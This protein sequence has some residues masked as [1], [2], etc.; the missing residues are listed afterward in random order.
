MSYEVA[1]KAEGGR[2]KR[3]PAYRDSGVEWLGSCPSHWCTARIRDHVNLVNGYPFDSNLFD[4][5]DGIPLVRIRDILNDQTGIVWTGEAVP[6]AAI[7]N[8]DILIGMDGDFNVSWWNGGYAMLNQRVCCIRVKTNNL[9]Q[10]FIFYLLHFPLKIINNLAYSTTVK[11]LSSFDVLK[12]RFARP[13]MEEQRAIA[14]FLDS[15]TGRID[16]LIAKKERQIELLREKRAA[17]ISHAVTRGLDPDAPMKD[18]GVE[19]LGEVPVG[20]AA[21]KTKYVATLRTGHTPGRQ[22]PEYWEDCIIPWFSL[23]DVW[24]LRDGRQEYLGETKEKIS[25]LGLANSSAELLPANTVIVSRTASVGFSGIMPE[26]M[27]TTQD[28]VNWVCSPK[29]QPEYLLYVFRSMEHEFKRLTMGSTH[30][31]IYMPDAASFQTPVPSLGEQKQIVKY[32]QK[33][34]RSLERVEDLVAVSIEKL[35]EYRTAL[36]SAAVTGK[37]DVREELVS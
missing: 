8:G 36:I 26:P 17:L 21:G 20:W 32:V 2:W 23:A 7:N 15:E 34:K 18:S 28:F 9:D 3:Y 13:S 4:I 19:W 33:H 37:I 30:K 6:E 25:A 11:H 24:Q 35:R 22:H 16:T 1:L 5:A 27:A 10:R 31:T 14:A 12:T 29:I